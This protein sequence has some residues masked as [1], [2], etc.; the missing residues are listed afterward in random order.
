M[1][2]KHDLDFIN[3]M[4]DVAVSHNLLTEVI[5]SFG[6]AKKDGLSTEEACTYALNDW[7]IL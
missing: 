3:D 6:I 4:M 7:D 1:D 5:Y 2:R